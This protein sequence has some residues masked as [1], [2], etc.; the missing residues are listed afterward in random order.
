MEGGGAPTTIA[1]ASVF[2]P[3]RAGGFATRRSAAPMA[4]KG[5][6]GVF[7][8]AGPQRDRR[9]TTGSRNRSARAAIEARTGPQHA[10]DCSGFA[11]G[12]EAEK[13]EKMK[14][15]LVGD[16]NLARSADLRRR[17]L[18]G[19]LIDVLVD[20]TEGPAVPDQM[21]STETQSEMLKFLSSPR[22]DRGRTSLARQA[23]RAGER[24]RAD[25]QARLATRVP[26]LARARASASGAGAGWSRC[27]AR[28]PSASPSKS[29]PSKGP[30]LPRDEVGRAARPTSTPSSRDLQ[31]HRRFRFCVESRVHS[32]RRVGLTEG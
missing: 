18:D 28:W 25:A 4:D 32:R 23:L 26:T 15:L 22:A 2:Q 16:A 10:G 7:G 29:G 13:Y 5:V 19:A 6:R 17:G 1:V 8:L 30:A 31:R 21:A 3:T 27:G 11:T 9:L 24:P 12:I 14:Y 20:P